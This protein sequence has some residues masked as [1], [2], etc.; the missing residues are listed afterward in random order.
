MFNCFETCFE[1]CSSNRKWGYNQYRVLGLFFKTCLMIFLGLAVYLAGDLFLLICI[2]LNIRIGTAAL[3]CILICLVTIV[4]ILV[5]RNVNFFNLYNYVFFLL[6]SA[7]TGYIILSPLHKGLFGLFE[8]NIMP[9]FVLLFWVCYRLK[10]N[11]PVSMLLCLHHFLLFFVWFDLMDEF[12]KW[13][14]ILQGLK[15]VLLWRD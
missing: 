2:F 7:C 12:L 8:G 4:L 3:I 9:F 13:M 14:S 15:H 6:L 1:L 10:M 5:Y 11:D